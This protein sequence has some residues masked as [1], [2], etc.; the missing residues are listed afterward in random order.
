MDQTSSK[1]DKIGSVASS[2]KGSIT[3][4]KAHNNQPKVVLLGQCSNQSDNAEGEDCG[5]SPVSLQWGPEGLQKQ[6]QSQ[7]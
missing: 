4:N 6:Q 2:T 7:E 1:K 3:G 5:T